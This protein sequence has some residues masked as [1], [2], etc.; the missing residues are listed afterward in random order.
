MYTDWQVIERCDICGGKCFVVIDQPGHILR[1]SECGFMFTSPRRSMEFELENNDH[2]FSQMV[3]SDSG[4]NY[5]SRLKIF[6]ERF[7]VFRSFCP[8]GNILD[9]GAGFG[10]FL[11]LCQQTGNYNVKGTDV[12]KPLVNIVLKLYG[13]K[14]D[15][16]SLEEINHPSGSFDAITMWHVLEHVPSPQNMVRQL[17]RL[18]KEKGLLFVAVPNE[19]VW[20]RMQFITNRIKT[21]VNRMAGR[22]ICKLKKMFPVYAEEGNWHL[23]HFTPTTLCKLLEKGGFEIL[24]V[25]PDANWDREH[26][27]AFKNLRCY[28]TAKILYP[29]TGVLVFNAMLMVA[30]KK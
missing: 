12:S 23:S 3:E 10:D 24:K 19:S 20:G 18:L 25:M 6:S 27:S 26:T 17:Y 30:R 16:G 15:S 11:H 5:N 2:L 14:I 1:C 29:I 4:Y 21:S 8:S 9:V 22:P 28:R 7:K 13:I